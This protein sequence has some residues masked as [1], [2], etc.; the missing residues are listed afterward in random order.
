MAGNFIVAQPYS[1][2]ATA[3]SAATSMP[4]S[5]LNKVQP[6][7]VWRS[8]SITG[9]VIEI[10]LGSAKAVDLVALMF[11]NLTS[12]ATW[13]V[14]AGTTTGVSDYD[15][16]TVTA[17][18]GAT[19][20]VDR[21]HAMLFMSS[22]QTYRY[23]KITLT[24]AANPASYFEAGRLILANAIQLTRNYAFGAGR[25]YI[26]LSTVKEA[27]GGQL[28]IEDKAKRPFLSFEA[29]WMTAA[30]MEGDVLEFQRSMTGAI[31]AM[32]TPDAST[33]RQARMYYGKLKLEP[34][35]V[36]SLNIYGTRFTVEG[37]I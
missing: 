24:D 32:L 11:T 5:N 29:N 33:Y 3:T 7:D 8:T 14:Q 19:Q 34:C 16:G 10:D 17:W 22:V 18:A 27:F 21:P 26:D 30:E 35:V 37:L 6:S 28:L 15:G 23:W 1:I 12:A 31:F 2:T 20:N 9:Q 36:S 13:R 4:A 25:G